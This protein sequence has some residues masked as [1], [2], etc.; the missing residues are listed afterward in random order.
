MFNCC[1]YG[2]ETQAGELI[3][4]AF[5]RK[6]NQLYHLD[7]TGGDRETIDKTR[8][9][10]RDLENCLEVALKAI[11]LASSRIQSLTNEELYPQFVALARG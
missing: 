11:Q 5:D 2:F 1:Y 8:A 7:A 6:R 3:R 9:T 4:M 10:L